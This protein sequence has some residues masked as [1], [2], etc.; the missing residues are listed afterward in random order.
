[1]IVELDWMQLVNCRAGKL[2]LGQCKLKQMTI[3]LLHFIILVLL[4]P[5]DDF[6]AISSI[7]YF[8]EASFDY[9]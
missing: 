8:A 6:K 4:P 2:S 1:M 3:E 7:T 9:S 5:L